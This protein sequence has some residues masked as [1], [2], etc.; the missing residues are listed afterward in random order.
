[1][2]INA[3]RGGARLDG[4]RVAILPWHTDWVSAE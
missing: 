3:E 2:D 1:M 4:S